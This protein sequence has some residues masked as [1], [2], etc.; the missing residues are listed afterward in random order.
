MAELKPM[1]CERCGGDI[2]RRTMRCQYCDTQYE[3]KH[4]GTQINYVVERPGIHRLRAE[5]RIADEMTRRDPEMAT[6]IAT[7]RLRNGIADGLLDYMKIYT[8]VDP[9]LMCQIIRGEVRVVDPT[10]GNY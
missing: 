1:V 3:R 9:M 4:E 5:V 2:D 6:K 7:D 8:N 10:F